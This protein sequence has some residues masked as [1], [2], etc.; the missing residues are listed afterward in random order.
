M[1]YKEWRKGDTL[2]LTSTKTKLELL[3][4]PKYIWAGNSGLFYAKV[5]FLDTGTIINDWMVCRNDLT[6]LSYENREERKIKTRR[7][8]NEI[9]DGISLEEVKRRRGIF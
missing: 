7:T 4:K 1:T 6:N 5:K 9:A 8:I 2:L 3:S